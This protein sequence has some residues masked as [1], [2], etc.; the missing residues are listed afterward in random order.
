MEN[1]KTL[2]RYKLKPE[3]AVER[4]HELLKEDIDKFTL[5]TSGAEEIECFV[6]GSKEYSLRYKKFGFDVVNCSECS[7]VYVNPRPNNEHLIKYYT[8]SLASAYFQEYI[9]APTQ[10]YRIDRIV[11]PRL[12][13]LLNKIPGKGKWLDVG[14]S[15]GLLLS[16]GAKTG[17]DPYGIEFEETSANAARDVGI[18]IYEKPIEDLG[19]E[20]KFD[21]VTMFEVLEHV[22]DPKGTLEHCFTAMTKGGHIV[23]TV[24]NI[25]GIEFEIL[26]DKHS[27]IA[28]PSH[29]NYFS[30]QTLTDILIKYGF[31]IVELDTPGLLDVSNLNIFMNK[32]DT[33]SSGNNS[34]DHILKSS[35][36]GSD[37]A[38]EKFQQVIAESNKSGHLRVIA[39]KV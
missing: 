35:D 37:E 34:L 32:D 28:P 30:P 3:G 25:E 9:I 16:E 6:C 23:I 19:I 36:E 17:W 5:N 27:N 4:Y 12:N 13:Y 21:L 26:E 29:L 22:A 14:C 33:L 7:M 18:F 38:R 2:E 24:P 8:E 1:N 11:K 20:N 15:S 10:E 39:K 31:E